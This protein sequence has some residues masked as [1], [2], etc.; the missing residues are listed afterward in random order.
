ML[1]LAQGHNNDCGDGGR[2]DGYV[3]L[4]CKARDHYIV[5]I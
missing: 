1:L 4:S 3:T 2:I 5:I